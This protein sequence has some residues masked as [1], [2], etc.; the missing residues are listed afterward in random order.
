MYLKFSKPKENTLI[1]HLM[2]FKQKNVIIESLIWNTFLRLTGAV[3]SI[4]Y[5][6]RNKQGVRCV[7]L[8]KRSICI[9]DFMKTTFFYFVRFLE[10]LAE[11]QCSSIT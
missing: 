11:D 6:V 5:Q 8:V 7:P 2:L 4:C 9:S 3:K 1:L 10:K